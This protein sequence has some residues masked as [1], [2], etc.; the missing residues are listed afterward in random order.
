MSR[1]TVEYRPGEFCDAPAV[2]WAPFPICARHAISL[3]KAVDATLRAAQGDRAISVKVALDSL[4]EKPSDRPRL[5]ELEPEAEPV[6][7]FLLIGELVKI[8]QS[9]NLTKR[10]AAYPPHAQLLATEY[11]DRAREA[12]LHRE[13]RE[14]L[15][16]GREWFTPGPRLREYVEDLANR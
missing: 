7:Y 8:G 13:F 6:V 10:L 16:S 11:G 9:N 3:Y 4:D 1:C 15:V 5:G 14:Y 2:E 12:Q